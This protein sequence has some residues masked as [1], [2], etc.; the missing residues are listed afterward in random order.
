MGLHLLLDAQTQG[1]DGR[2]YM[3]LGTASRCCRARI[4]SSMAP[5][6]HSHLQR[7]IIQ[8]SSSPNNCELF[9]LSREI[10]CPSLTNRRI[11]QEN[12]ALFIWRNGPQASVL[13]ARAGSSSPRAAPPD[14]SKYETSREP[15][16]ARRQ[17][18]GSLAARLHSHFTPAE[19]HSLPGARR[20]P[21]DLERLDN[22]RC[23][24]MREGGHRRRLFLRRAVRNCRRR[25][26]RRCAYTH[27]VLCRVNRRL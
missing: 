5:W 22:G 17:W 15:L 3:P 7:R 19:K 9:G 27:R 18:Q 13:R 24:Q 10:A 12:S 1:M 14:A 4:R 25:S 8:E 6:W 21:R 26:T 20:C 11:I 2:R 23:N 16:S